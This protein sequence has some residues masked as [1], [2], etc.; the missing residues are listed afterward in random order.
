MFHL[1][2]SNPGALSELDI[3]VDNSDYLTCV[4]SRTEGFS[5]MEEIYS[6]SSVIMG[7]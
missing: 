2:R 4:G 1:S 7:P 5:S 6:V 3:N